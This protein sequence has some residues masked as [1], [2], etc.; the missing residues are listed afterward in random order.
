MPDLIPRVFLGASAF[1]ELSELVR[2]INGIKKTYE[3]VGILDDNE[4]LH[5]TEVEGYPVMGPLSLAEN[6]DGKSF[7]LGI[8]SYKTRIAR[9]EIFKRLGLP[10][11]R[12][13]TLVHPF[14]KIYYLRS[15][16]FKQAIL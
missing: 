9:F 4:A 16:K 12:Y 14:A 7:V 5:E 3:I 15:L 2:D 8:G 11:E 6:M 13:A 1:P 10:K